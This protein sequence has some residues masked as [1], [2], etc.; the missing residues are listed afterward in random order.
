MKAVKTGVLIALLLISAV[1]VHAS[2]GEY[3]VDA[4]NGN[5]IIGDGSQEKPWMTIPSASDK[6]SR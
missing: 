6:G 5:N 1:N 2:F 4:V 3:Y